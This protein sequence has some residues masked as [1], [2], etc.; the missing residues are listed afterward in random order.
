MEKGVPII[1]SV[2]FLNSKNNT[3]GVID[4]LVRNDYISKLI[5]NCPPFENNESKFGDYHYV[6]IDIK[7]STIELKKDK[8]HIVN[9]KKFKSYKTQL[10]IYNDAI[11]NIQNFTPR[12]SYILGIKYKNQSDIFYSFDKLGTVDFK[13]VDKYIIDVTRKSIEWIRN[14][15]NNSDKMILNP[16]SIIELYPN[17]NVDSGIWN[18]K[19]EE[20]SK[21]IGEITSIWNVGIKNRDKALSLGITSWKDSRCNSEILGIKNKEKANI[22]DSI[23]NINRQDEYKIL[24]KKIINNVLNWKEYE[25]EIFVDFETLIDFNF[26][27]NIPIIFMIGVY[28]KNNNKWEYKSFICNNIC[29]EEEYRIIND[30]VDFLIINKH[31]KLWYWYADNKIWNSAINRHLDKYIKENQKEKQEQISNRW[32]NLNW[33]DMSKIFTKE[34]I[35]IK[36]C[37][38][39]SLKNITKAMNSN[40]LIKYKLKS[41]CNNGMLASVIALD[42]YKNSTNPLS[43]E[44]FKDIENYNKFDVKILYKLIYYLRNN[45]M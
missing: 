43:N 24:P 34:P 3:K 11:G 22:I 28:W 12:Y 10:N 39:F 29:Y 7:Y 1:H 37:F 45:H 26:I 19:K 27:E 6:V 9:S 25:N 13:N 20:I 33:L 31:P 44:L 38:N 5:K 16:P 32:N 14:V 40:N 8:I 23:L 17:M 15:K 4:L 36:D 42:I 41:D 21:N 35:V 18:Y 30:F 2:P